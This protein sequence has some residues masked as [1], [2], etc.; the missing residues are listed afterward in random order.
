[1]HDTPDSDNEMIDP[2]LKQLT[3]SNDLAQLSNHIDTLLVM[4]DSLC[5]NYCDNYHKLKCT[6]YSAPIANLQQEIMI[7]MHMITY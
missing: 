7:V 4:K 6:S 5:M 2:E 1:M 3:V